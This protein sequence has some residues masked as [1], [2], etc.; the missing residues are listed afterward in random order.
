MTLSMG[1][2]CIKFILS[3]RSLS[4]SVHLNSVHPLLV[5]YEWI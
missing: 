5:G 1:Y 3:Q 2:M 4:L